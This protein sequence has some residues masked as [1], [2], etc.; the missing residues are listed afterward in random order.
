MVNVDF[1]DLASRLN[2][3]PVPPGNYAYL[4]ATEK[5]LCWL[6]RNE[7]DPP[8]LELQCVDIANKGDQPDTVMTT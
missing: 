4:Q 6:Q 7:D 3:V 1:T 8:K 2:E 5:R